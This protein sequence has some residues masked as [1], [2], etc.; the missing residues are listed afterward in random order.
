MAPRR[1]NKPKDHHRRQSSDSPWTTTTRHGTELPQEKN[2]SVNRAIEGRVRLS[3][4]SVPFSI[5]KEDDDDD[6]ATITTHIIYL[7]LYTYTILYRS[8]TQQQNTPTEPEKSLYISSTKTNTK[9]WGLMGCIH[10]E[11]SRASATPRNAFTTA[12]TKATAVSETQK[13]AH[14]YYVIYVSIENLWANVRAAHFTN[15]RT[16]QCYSTLQYSTRNQ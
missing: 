12:P 8:F 3:V 13:Y 4:S 5:P 14:L 10:R 9:L 7:P 1:E 6:N 11:P 16:K 15:E 2:S